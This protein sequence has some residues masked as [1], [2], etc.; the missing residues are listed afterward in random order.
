MSRNYFFFLALFF[1]TISFTACDPDDPIIPNEE[2]LITSL[3][4]S[5]T[6]SDGTAV[7]TFSFQD[8]DGDG[9]NA[10]IIMVATLE[11]NTTYT[12]TIS[13][14]NEAED[15]SINIT[16][17]IE[18]EDEDHQFFYETDVDGLSIAYGDQDGTGNPVGLK[19]TLTTGDAGS[20]T[21]KITLRHEPNKSADGVTA[22][23]ISNAGG[24]TDIEVTFI[25]DVQ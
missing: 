17:E 9:G 10:P 3:V 16:T 22:G 18:E 25:V 12:G 5:L 2:E 14:M 20:G 21:L 13:I 23:I 8:L 24:E 6:P 15:P 19:T 4:Y 1:F 11:A 7:K